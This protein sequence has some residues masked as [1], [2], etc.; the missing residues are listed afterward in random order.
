MKLPRWNC[1]R[2]N[3][4][5]QRELEC[6]FENL[7]LDQLNRLDNNLVTQRDIEDMVAMDSNPDYH[8][9]V[10]ELFFPSDQQLKR[11]QLRARVVK[12]AKAKDARLVL[13]L[14][15]KDPELQ[16]LADQL[17]TPKRGRPKGSRKKDIV[18]KN[19][20]VIS[21]DIVGEERDLLERAACDV[22]RIYDLWQDTI[23]EDNRSHRYRT[24]SP[25]AVEIAARRWGVDA[26]KLMNF[27][28]NFKRPKWLK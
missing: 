10:W 13:R 2:N 7:T 3:P 20:R 1:H 19:K 22:Y 26:E 25:T 18:D 17:L 5:L 23:W 4:L 6:E 28:R 11:Q 9:W 15:A 12:A 21:A 14:T 27:K 24:Q 8:K 16:Q